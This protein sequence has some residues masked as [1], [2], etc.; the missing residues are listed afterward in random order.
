MDAFKRMRS[1]K[2]KNIISRAVLVFL[3][4]LI[5]NSSCNL[6][7]RIF[8]DCSTCYTDIPIY[9]EQLIR[10]SIDNETPEVF[11]TVY[12]GPWEKGNVEFTFTMFENEQTVVLRTDKHYT[13][14][15]EY[16]K[17]GRTYYVI[18]GCILKVLEDYDSCDEPCY[19]VR[20]RS[21][22]LR[23]KF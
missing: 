16:T 5:P 22:D 17:N 3:L 23:L 15:A 18:N 6:I 7:D 14:R 20:H 8:V 10:V 9:S 13:L 12:E 11:I 4:F 19:Y 21:V 1:L 2:I